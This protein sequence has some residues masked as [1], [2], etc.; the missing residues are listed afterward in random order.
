MRFFTDSPKR[1]PVKW[2]WCDPTAKIFPAHHRFG[3]GNWASDEFH[4][5]G[6]GEV[7]GCKASY[8][9]GEK[10]PGLDGQHFCGPLIGFTGGT[11]FPGVPLNAN[12]NG[13]AP[14]CTPA[15]VQTCHDFAN[16]TIPDVMYAII[17]AINNPSNPPLGIVGQAFK[18]KRDPFNHGVLLGPSY[19]PS[20][21]PFTRIYFK[22]ECVPQPFPQPEVYMITL[23][24]DPVG[25][26]EGAPW[27]LLENYP[28]VAFR[29]DYWPFVESTGSEG[30]D[31]LFSTVSTYVPPCPVM[32]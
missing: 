30:W 17:T 15:I 3:S 29:A 2:F 8:S 22:L 7:Q 31:L 12:V 4:W 32:P 9:L 19:I 1:T 14:C 25:F 11:K 23:N 20:S 16:F 28:P 27:G 6:P 5:D 10:P 26:L 24:G 21:G 18:F 13:I